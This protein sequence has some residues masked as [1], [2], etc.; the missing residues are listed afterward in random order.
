MR[1]DSSDRFR[2]TEKVSLDSDR[3]LLEFHQVFLM[4]LQQEVEE[5]VVELLM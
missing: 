1:R 3:R 2:L 5:V 4:E